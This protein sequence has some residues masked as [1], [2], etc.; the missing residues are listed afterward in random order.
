[1][2]KSVRNVLIRKIGE[3]LIKEM[4]LAILDHNRGMHWLGVWDEFVQKTVTKYLW[5]RCIKTV[6]LPVQ[7]E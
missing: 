4:V 2:G 7:A 6:A 3:I 1:M 5:R